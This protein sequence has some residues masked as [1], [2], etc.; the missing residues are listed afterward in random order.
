MC[1]YPGAHVKVENNVLVVPFCHVYPKVRT[2][3]I[4]PGSRFLHLMIHLTDFRRVKSLKKVRF[5]LNLWY[6]C[7]NV[8]QK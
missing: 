8:P 2:R 4:R 6:K 5:Q 3:V 7:T 1:M